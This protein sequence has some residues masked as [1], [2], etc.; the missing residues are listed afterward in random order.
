MTSPSTVCPSCGEDV[1]FGRRTCEACGANVAL[2]A[3]DEA[4]DAGVVTDPAGWDIRKEVVFE[5][6]PEP[7]PATVEPE[8]A[9]FEPEAA[10]FEPE[11]ATFEPEAADLAPAEPGPAAEPPAREAADTPFMPPVLREW[12]PGSNVPE[13]GFATELAAAE[14]EPPGLAGAW[15]PPA[16]GARQ[17][18]APAMPRWP[19]N[20]GT[21]SMQVAGSGMAAA[22]EPVSAAGSMPSSLTEMLDRSPAA[23]PRWPSNVERA[24]ALDAAATSMASPTPA[25]MAPTTGAPSRPLE[26]GRAPL[27]ADLPFDAPNTLP[28]WFVAAGGGIATIA[29]LLP[30]VAVLDSYFSAWGL[31]SIANLPAFLV[32]FGVTALAIL[33]SRL[34]D[35]LRHGILGLTVGAF[36]LGLTWSRLVGASGGQIGVVLEGAGA[37]LLLIGGILAI[38]RDRGASDGRTDPR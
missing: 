34:A 13:T 3:H 36:I 5:P 25:A 1:P 38:V 12:N 17:P 21:Q 8:A 29:F 2:V 33:P 35:W 22:A 26:P 6:I 37:L 15:L 16:S 23:T 24:A 14:A 18:A 11:A 4:H 9:V 27:F 30:W 10:L 28:G 7:E 20:P 32:V 19:G 31:G